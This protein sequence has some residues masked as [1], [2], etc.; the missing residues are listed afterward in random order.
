MLIK[1]SK[2]L[3]V[4]LAIFAVLGGLALFQSRSVAEEKAPA[5]VK[6]DVAAL[7]KDRVLGK[8][9]A[10]ITMI[11]YASM[12]C[13]HCAHFALDILPKVKEKLIETGKV[14]LIFRDFPMDQYGLKAAMM[15]RC[16][17][18]DKYFNMVEAI[19]S[20]QARWTSA[21]EP[22]DALAQLA[23]LA[24]MDRPAFDA[25][26]DNKELETALLAG[27]QTAQEKYALQSTPTFILNEGAGRVDG[28][29][30]ID[31]FEKEVAKIMKGK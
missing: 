13:P 23:A 24:G 17:P 26:L 9:D 27:V 11:E 19:F 7:M 2:G 15:A 6:A 29:Q 22:L 12:T 30:D 21:K 31:A 18:E 4:C 25:C 5:P 20:N 28:A 10:P 14:K 1:N 8:A 3:A 16:L